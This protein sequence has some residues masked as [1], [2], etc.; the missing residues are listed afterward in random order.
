M[1]M[2]SNPR[3][4]PPKHEK[5]FQLELSKKAPNSFLFILLLTCTFDR[6]EM[7]AKEKKKDEAIYLNFPGY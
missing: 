5:N 2:M 3:F 1:F 7:R 4:H 6:K